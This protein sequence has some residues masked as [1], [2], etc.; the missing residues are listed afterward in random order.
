[1]TDFEKLR[2]KLL[3]GSGVD[4]GYLNEKDAEERKKE[5]ERQAL[6]QKRKQMLQKHNTVV[7]LDEGISKDRNAYN[8]NSS[9]FYNQL[10][11]DF[12]ALNPDSY[13]F[14][15]N[16]GRTDWGDYTAT[17]DDIKFEQDKIRKH[18]EDNRSAY[19]S[20]KVD[21][22]LK[23]LDEYN[24]AV[25]D[26]MSS[27]NE[28]R[29]IMSQ[30]KTRD[31]YDAALKASEDW[32]NAWGHYQD[33]EDFDQFSIYGGQEKK[34]VGFSLNPNPNYWDDPLREAINGNDEAKNYLWY[35]AYRTG[36]SSEAGTDVFSGQI[37]ALNE[38]RNELKEMSK[39]EVAI[40]NY[41]YATEGKEKAH[42][43]YNAIQGDLRSREM[44]KKLSDISK[45]ASEHEFT[46]SLATILASPIKGLS[47]ASMGADYLSGNGIDINKGS[48]IF[49]RGSTTARNAIAQEIEKTGW[50]KVGSWGYQL[51]MSMGDSLMAIGSGGGGAATLAIMG[52]GAAAD[53]TISAKQRGLTDDQAFLLGSIAGT[54]EAATEK[55]GVD[56]FLDTALAGSSPIKYMLRNSLGEGTEELL[57]GVGNFIAD[58]AIAKDKSEWAAIMKKYKSQGM[59]D[60]KAFAMAVLETS[61]DIALDTLGGI[62]SGAGFGGMGLATS[63]FSN[64]ST[65]RDVINNGSVEGLRDMAGEY[66]QYADKLDS[67]HIEGLSNKVSAE[68]KTGEGFFGKI[69]AG[70]GN[71]V[72]Q[73]RV[74]GL[75]NAVAATVQQQNTADIKTAL[76]A[77]GLKGGKLKTATD[78]LSNI[79]N[80][81]EISDSDLKFLGK[82]DGAMSVFTDVILDK[83][84]SV[85]KR[86]AQLAAQIKGVS[87]QTAEQPTQGTSEGRTAPEA[88][89]KAPTN[90]T[91]DT[92]T[93]EAAE[94]TRRPAVTNTKGAAKI[95]KANGFD[96]DVT[97]LVPGR[98]I[99]MDGKTEW[100]PGEVRGSSYSDSIDN[101]KFAD[102][103]QGAAWNAFANLGQTHT[104]T[105]VL[106]NMDANTATELLSLYNE[107]EN[108]S[109]T[110][111]AEEILNAYFYGTIGA[112]TKFAKFKSITEEQMQAAWEL[113]NK[114]YES[115]ANTVDTETANKIAEAK[116]KLAESGK[117][118][119]GTGDVVLE[120]G[121]YLEDFSKTEK[122]SYDIAVRV[123]KAANVKIHIYRGS[124]SEFGAYN[125]TTDEIWLNINAKHS[126]KSLMAFTLAHELVH[127]ARKGSPA[128][129]RAFQ[130]FL[131][132]NYA[133]Q[134]SSLD[135]MIDQQIKAANE[136]DKTIDDPK[137]RINMTREMALEEVVCDACERMLLDSSVNKKLAQFASLSEENRTFVER[138]KEWIEQFM[139]K[140][141]K[142]FQDVDPTNL[143][144]YEFEKFDVLVKN[145]LAEM[146][147]DMSVDAGK[148]LAALKAA[149][150]A[151]IEPGAK[152]IAGVEIIT[153]GAVVVDGEETRFSIKSMKADIADGKM[154]DDLKTHCG[155]SQEQVDELKGNLENLVEYMTPFRDILDMNETYGKKGRRF[156]PYKP[157]SDP[158]YKISLDFSTLCSKRL[159]TQYV[160]EQLQL[161]ENRPMSAEEQ[162]AIR[163]MLNEYR[164]V[165]KGLQ[166]ACAM[167][168]VEAARLKSPKQINRWLADPKPHLINYFAQKNAEFKAYVEGKQADF[169]ES[170]G[171]ARNTPKKDMKQA[172]VTALNK[173]GP[174]LRAEYKPSAEEQA[175][176]D[177]AV[178][179]PNST[180]LT[181]AN[182]ANLSETDPVLYAAYTAFVRTATRSKSLETD[183]PYYYGD[184]TR[185]NGNGVVVTDSFIEAVNK[186]NGMRFSSWSD[187]RIQHLLDYITAVI[188]NSV[189]GAA[190]H[191]YTKFGEEVR[192][193]GKT[194]MMF[195]MSGVAGTQNG[196]NEDGTLNFSD[197]ESINVEEAKQLRN[198]FPDTAG[199]QCIGVSDAHVIALLA[200]N[201]IDY[202]IPY[203]VSGLN[204]GLRTMASINGW[205]DYTSTQHATVDKSAKIED[206]VDKENWHEE[207]VFSEFFV[208]YDTG[209]T[210]IEAMRASAER[211][212]QMCRDR[213]LKP[214]FEQ[215]AN[216]G[217]YWKLLIDR[218]MINQ[219]TGKLI[220]Q[221]PVTPTFDFAV[222][223]NVVDQYVANYDANMESKALDYI[224]ENFDSI[225]KRIRDLKK[226]GKKAKATSKAIDT[227]SNETLAA[228]P[229]D[230]IVRSVP[231]SAGS[232][233]SKGK[234]LSVNQQNY[235]AFSVVRNA[236]GNL[237]V[238]YHGTS[239]GGHTVF[240]AW[241]KGKYGL[242]GIGTYFTES[243]AIA[244]SYTQKG[245]GNNPQVY[246]CY[247]NIKNPMDMDAQADPAEWRNAF[248]EADF[249]E[250][251]TNEE[252]YRSAEQYLEDEMIPRW[253]GAERMLDA[254]QYTMGYDGITHIGGGRVDLNGER[255]RVYIAFEPEQIKSVDNL[256]PTD[257]V[258]ISRKL[259]VE[260]D[261]SPRALLA[262]ALESVAT[263]DAELKKLRQYKANIET[264]NSLESRL[265][266]LRAEIKKLSFAKGK[267]DTARIAELRDEATKT[268][269]RI[270]I[271]DSKLLRLEATSVL[272][273]VV[274]RERQIAAAKRKEIQ[275]EHRRESKEQSKE[276]RLLEEE[277]IRLRK[278]YEKE[279]GRKVSSDVEIQRLKQKAKDNVEGRK[280]T[281]MRK[282][283]RKKIR[284][285]TKLFQGGKDSPN[286]KKE[287]RDA[288][289]TAIAAGEVLFID[290]YTTDDMIRNGITGATTEA[291]QLLNEAKDILY[292][293]DN[294]PAVINVEDIAAWDK[295]ERKYR[296]R[297]NEIKAQLKQVF[298][299][300]RARLEGT[301]VETLMDGLYKAYSALKNSDTEYIKA[302]FDPKTLETLSTIREGFGTVSIKEMRLDQLEQLY[303]AYGMVLGTVRNSNKL[304]GEMKK[305]SLAETIQYLFDNTDR[306]VP[307]TKLAVIA[308]KVSDSIGWDYEKL[309]YA[310]ERINNPVITELFTDLA[311]SENR[312]MEAVEEAKQEMLRIVEKYGY[313]KWK[314]D[315]RFD[316][317]F[318]DN[319]G[320][321]FQL[322]LGEVM[323]LYAYT[324]RDS[325]WNHLEVGGFV[326]ATTKL[327]ELEKIDPYKLTKKQCEAIINNLTDDQKHFVEEMQRFLSE[328]MGAKGNEVSMMLYGIELFGEE[329]YFPIRIVADFMARA[330]DA[331]AKEAAGFGSMS[332]AGFTH[333][334]NQNSVSPVMM[335][336]FM[337]VWTDH[338][339]EMSR[340][341]GTVPALENIRKVMNYQYSYDGS[342]NSVS[343]KVLL[344]NTYGKK[345]VEYL[346]DLYKEANTGAIRDKMQGLLKKAVSLTRKNSVA[347]SASTWIQQP[348]SIVRAFAIIPRK[349][350]SYL[351]ATA[352]VLRGTARSVLDRKNYLQ[353]YAEMRKYAPGVTI[354][355]EIGGFDTASGRSILSY[356]RDTGKNTVQKWQ[357]SD[358]KG[359]IGA[360]MDVVDDNFISNIPEVMDKIAWIEIWNACKREVHATHKTL[361]PKSDEFFETVG[362]R[363][364]EVIRAT[365]VYDSIFSK[366][367]MLKSQN[368]AVQYM[369][370]FM[371]EPNTTANMVESGI[372]DI[373]SGNLGKGIKKMHGALGSVIFT[374]LLSSIIYALRDDDEDETYIEK[375]LAS[376]TEKFLD[377]IS[378][379]NYI[380][381]LRDVWSLTKGFDVSRPDTDIISSVISGVANVIKN[382]NVDTSKMTEWELDQFMKQVSEDNWK[383]AGAIGSA[384]GIPLKNIYR[385][386]KAFL[387]Y[388]G[389]PVKETTMQKIVDSLEEAVNNSS[390][391]FWKHDYD[392][393]SKKLYNAIVNGDDK[394]IER[395]KPNYLDKHGEFSQE[396]FDSAV[397]SA[398][399]E[400]DPRIADAA[401]AQINGDPSRRVEIAEDI[402]A[403]GFDKE[404][405][406]KAINSAINKMTPSEESTPKAYGFYD[407]EDFALEIA[408]GDKDGAKAAKDGYI[409]TKMLNGK[410][411]DEAVDAFN[412]AAK[413]ELKKLYISGGLTEKQVADAMERY[414]D[415]DSDDI[416][417]AVKKWDYEKENGT[418]EGYSKYNDFH[419]A[420]QTGKNLK[421]VINE[422]TSY[423]VKT[424][425]LAG[426][427][428]D[429]FKP[430]YKSMTKSQRAS[431][432]GYLLNAYEKLGYDRDK[433][434]KS[435]DKW[436]ED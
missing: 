199:L 175:I 289:A 323:S 383:M 317:V 31:E 361:S 3:E 190:M 224:V 295:Q 394:Y 16:Y 178:Q 128:Q 85:N 418:T 148:N 86:N 88:E 13:D 227:V 201:I 291:S 75:Y 432:K 353:D 42:E 34:D 270:K 36:S 376:V 133:R 332:N 159:L 5:A 143:A 206:A 318:V 157:N 113:G 288:I 101:V 44:S 137:K 422:Y 37:N 66:K 162:M 339:N 96:G 365:Q 132:D 423:G 272:Q 108:T 246:E 62:V 292:Q 287:L 262:Q 51:G 223:K 401:N 81:E 238:M 402:M 307:K 43:F 74:G 63:A 140:L 421:S 46:T 347:Y 49:S 284:D 415:T 121:V 340:Y 374:A 267:R 24:T 426:E 97:T 179:M 337:N 123:S 362:K 368:M 2:K 149:A 174:K 355:K 257:N 377:D 251:G 367:P 127:R 241:G 254:I 435:I 69:G 237:M 427:I 70:V 406:R 217:N 15:G 22:V 297:L 331:Q 357:T 80:G 209:M 210:G 169:K 184:S 405:V 141:R 261:T 325:A 385:D 156:S 404:V 234:E 279:H 106:R 396:K 342:V 207:P 330:Q 194:G 186:E 349:Y 114:L 124:T 117:R 170:R 116:K 239:Y 280:K 195:N 61:G 83:N 197:T 166:V 334:Q 73:A 94:P 395:L 269:N 338:V 399:K 150:E 172:D 425:D 208:G 102:V 214:K 20:Q 348:A 52:S 298:A 181:A 286:V 268:A 232:V 344:R 144:A 72:N 386:A 17:W 183:E 329:N 58:T 33:A 110:A 333:V 326:P 171:Y 420:V 316:T 266:E 308:R 145:Q 382:R 433:K 105:E 387:G 293:L 309:Y 109:G 346:D 40:F 265:Q 253:E 112:S 115:T 27:I 274:D 379:F 410:T 434:S 229:T 429:Y 205:K 68:T 29:S 129:Y 282:K 260:Q 160:I 258:D 231:K 221:K 77:E 152:P 82:N 104:S 393:K 212:K 252:F 378:V 322:T 244:E 296:D 225:P 273:K 359:K 147:V 371:N 392:S 191:G 158:L 372:R 189:R 92:K 198:E 87:E 301:T 98:Y 356:L 275:A 247:L 10:L 226:G 64:A 91:V 409:E 90:E 56:A 233:D 138:I 400:H 352:S 19:G 188:D 319:L 431:L 315:E 130:K 403:D 303:K 313:N 89:L 142:L 32:Y 12:D 93:E 192:V 4:S 204:K 354:A 235:F 350:F 369:V 381:Y 60:A 255:H 419:N 243:K 302:A 79:A 11:S 35:E 146:F 176:I 180:Y 413:S 343:T 283:I 103:E 436:L 222:I 314:V 320:K 164:K 119:T 391:F 278:E 135:A 416:H 219:K 122:A 370:S 78:I 55:I 53:V 126:A 139:D 57:S 18:Y 345:A 250:S 165:A 417:W 193:L 216:E 411:K 111:F 71:F 168:Y 95:K 230:D 424:S 213:G 277:N 118:V 375:Y 373:A 100:V 360:V 321:E 215:F 305:K 220:Q 380:P 125:R 236:A 1:M 336:S 47:Y 414:C 182:L 39:D 304:F 7:G 54:I 21:N 364:T 134:G 218:K 259:P 107:E 264:L 163:D 388:I 45:Y 290:N 285:L 155:W 38:G 153:D 26:L 328:N 389:A 200:S 76:E 48:A 151:V 335:E 6:A 256:N 187:W 25:E 248:P 366:S 177:R 310:L 196:L 249:F 84:S 154:F 242:F 300:E 202:V 397:T 23:G 412:S 59:S 341:Y 408:N 99:E 294:P 185:D 384:V 136:F 276:R 430:I 41:L 67:R 363:F 324:R 211:Y 65:G 281:E 161:R 271:M 8:T 327:T 299:D 9:N 390:P 203:H 228:Q 120:D 50:G 14:A 428:T 306:E 311:N 263:D 398:L 30:L 167:C 358:A 240:D 131:L 245:K 407:A 351:G 173:I 28:N 312:V